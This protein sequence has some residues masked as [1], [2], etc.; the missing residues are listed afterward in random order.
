MGGE[1]GG[2]NIY[3]QREGKREKGGRGGICTWVLACKV[4]Y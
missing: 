3:M 1:E 4:L 2:M